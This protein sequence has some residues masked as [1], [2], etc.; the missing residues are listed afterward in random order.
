MEITKHQ[1]EYA[2]NRIEELLPLVTE[3]TLVTDPHSIE[4]EVVSDIVEAYEKTHFPIAHSAQF[5]E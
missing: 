2:L 5:L 3:D 1:Y 4:F